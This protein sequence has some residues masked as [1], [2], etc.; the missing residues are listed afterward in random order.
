MRTLFRVQA[1][2]EQSADA[3]STFKFSLIGN[4]LYLLVFSETAVYAKAKKQSVSWLFGK[5]LLY[6]LN[7]FY[8]FYR[9][10]DIHLHLKDLSHNINCSKA[11]RNK[12]PTQTTAR[13]DKKYNITFQCCIFTH[14]QPV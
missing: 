4:F 9:F 12:L 11:G 8:A 10:N 6:F 2:S 7:F 14:N 5:N 1:R 13:K 3:I